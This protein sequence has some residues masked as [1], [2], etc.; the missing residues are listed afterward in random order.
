MLAR[1]AFARRA[2]RCVSTAALALARDAEAGCT[3]PV[4]LVELLRGVPPCEAPDAEVVLELTPHETHS[5]LLGDAASHEF[6]RILWRRFPSAASANAAV[7]RYA[8]S[9]VFRTQGRAQSHHDSPLADLTAEGLWNN[10]SVVL[11]VDEVML[12]DASTDAE[13]LDV[14]CQHGLDRLMASPTGWSQMID[15]R[16]S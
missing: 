9:A 8:N 10:H 12:P 6:D 1:L 14:L 11:R 3:A 13:A 2:R 15:H 4:M 7:V 16:S 5:V